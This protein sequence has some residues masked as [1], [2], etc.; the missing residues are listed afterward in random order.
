MLVAL[1]THGYSNYVVN[2]MF[3][4]YARPLLM[5][6]HEDLDTIPPE[7]GYVFKFGTVPY[8]VTL[9]IEVP[10]KRRQMM[11]HDTLQLWSTSCS[12]HRESKWWNY[13]LP[14]ADIERPEL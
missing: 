4:I 12:D 2:R 6:G 9:T 7:I 5:A 14:D 11:R 1:N 10:Y 3:Q 13:G 8:A